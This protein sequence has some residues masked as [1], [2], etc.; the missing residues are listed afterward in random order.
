MDLLNL[1]FLRDK[2]EEED[3]TLVLLEPLAAEG[4]GGRIPASAADVPLVAPGMDLN[5]PAKID[6]LLPGVLHPAQRGT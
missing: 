5:V 6:P 1:P 2:N 3:N 4:A